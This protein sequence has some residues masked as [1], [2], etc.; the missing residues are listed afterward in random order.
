MMS[1]KTMKESLQSFAVKK[2]LHYLD[3]DP[4]K[5]LPKLLEWTDRFDKDNMFAGQRRVFR[6]ILA[7]PALNIGDMTWVKVME[8]DEKGRVN[9]SRKDAMREM[10]GAGK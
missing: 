5:S 3:E 10:N 1:Q 9:L 8:I 7:H 6:E 4:V 2:V